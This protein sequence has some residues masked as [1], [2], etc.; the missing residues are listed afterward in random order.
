MDGYPLGSLDH[1]VPLLV[2]SGLVSA[3]PRELGLSAELNEQA[4]PIRSDLPP[5]DGKAAKVLASYL[6]DVDSRQDA[7]NGR[8]TGNGYKFRVMTTGRVYLPTHS[9]HFSDMAS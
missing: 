7:W 2:A 4:I 5:L 9:A 3:P 1:N 8:D 6:G